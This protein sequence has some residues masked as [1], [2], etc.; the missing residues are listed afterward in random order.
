[1]E[2]LDFHIN[3][4]LRYSL[5]LRCLIQQII[6]NKHIHLLK[7]IVLYNTDSFQK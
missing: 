6:C 3:K 1:M 2:D 7:Y 5:K 4:N